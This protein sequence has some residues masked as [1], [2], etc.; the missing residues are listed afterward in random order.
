MLYIIGL[1]LD[2]ED[3]NAKA[4]KAIRKCKEVYL[5]MYTSPFPYTVNELSKALRKKIITVERDFIEESGY[6][7]KAAKRKEI[8]LLVYGDPLIATTHISLLQEARKQKVKTEVIHNISILN[9]ITNTGLEAYKFS[10]ITSIPKWT[11]SF[12]P[13]SFFNVLKQNS[14]IGAH[15]LFLL[16]YELDLGEAMSYLL[17]ISE[18]DD[19]KYFSKKTLCIACSSLGTKKQKIKYGT[20]EKLAKLNLRKPLSLI[21]P[22]KLHFVE[23]EFLKEF[24]VR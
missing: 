4:L 11:S 2:K 19:N 15:T 13:T 16:D 12:K 20:A 18:K 8:A 17:Q 3:L 23:E 1:G 14:K 5:E 24:R 9:A 10:R 21:I 22:G 7:V 6:L